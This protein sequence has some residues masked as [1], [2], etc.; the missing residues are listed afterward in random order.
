[1]DP[2]L[3]RISQLYNTLEVNRFIRFDYHI[4]FHGRVCTQDVV[5]LQHKRQFVVLVAWSSWQFSFEIIARI[6]S[7]QR[8]H[9]DVNV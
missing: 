8:K 5:H 4:P 9:A 1:M 3:H 7:L 2:I 6:A